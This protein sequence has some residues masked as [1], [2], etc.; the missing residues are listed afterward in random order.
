ADEL[1]RESDRIARSV[2]AELESLERRLAADP[3]RPAPAVRPLLEALDP[4][5]RRQLA[6]LVI[7]RVTVGP[8][9]SVVVTWRH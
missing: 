5:R 3:G 1:L 6:L 4:G 8:D 9:G 2:Q 7:D